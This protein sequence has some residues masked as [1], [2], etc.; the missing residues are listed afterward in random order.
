MRSRRASWA[1]SWLTAIA[2]ALATLGV[3]TAQAQVG[4]PKAKAG[5]NKAK[6]KRREPAKRNAP[7]AADPIENGAADAL[8]KA[9]AG[10]VHYRLK[11]KANDETSLNLVYYPAYPAR[12]GTNAPVIMMVHEKDRSSRDFEEPIAELKKQGFAEHMQSLGYAVLAVDLRGH[13]AN[14]RK[15]LTPQDWR[16]M[17]G[18]LQ[19]AYQFLVDRH[20]RG[21]L[22]LAK[23]GVMGV[24]EGANL[25]A[26][27]AN[28]PGGGVSGEG[29]TSDLGAMVLVSPL[30]DGSGFVLRQVMSSLAPR[31]PLLLMAGER[32]PISAD[33]VRAVRPFVERP[34]GG[35]KQNRVEFF[36]SSLHGYKLL[37]L[38]PKVTSVI[39]KFFEGT[40]KLKATTPWEPRYNLTPVQYED[41]QLVRSAKDKDA[42]A[43]KAKEPEKA[44]EKAIE[45][46]AEPK[47]KEEPAP[48][49]KAAS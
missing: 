1:V 43:E 24:G 30:A 48:A 11:I 37:W 10:M 14:V 42:A 33:P 25:V 36:D 16:L 8:D 23:L 18:D 35:M 7:N 19:A 21:K 31:I 39:P 17:V 28:T 47:A 6:N 26:A 2:M 5:T 49:K 3:A 9:A 13:G 45:K 12:L 27:W 22:N 20:N 40:I 15:A 46:K 38:E 29:R 34:A 41:I 32:D 44:K 4:V